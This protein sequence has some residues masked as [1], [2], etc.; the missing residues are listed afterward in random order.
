MTLE[1]I[2]IGFIVDHDPNVSVESHRNLSAITVRVAARCLRL[3]ETV[4][5]CKVA[6]E[7]Q[8]RERW[9][10]ALETQRVRDREDVVRFLVDEDPNVTAEPVV[11][12]SLLSVAVAS[13]AL[14]LSPSAL[15]REVAEAV[16]RKIKEE[17]AEDDDLSDLV[18]SVG[19]VLESYQLN[20][21]ERAAI[22]NVI[23]KW[24][25]TADCFKTVYSKGFGDGVNRALN[26][27][28]SAMEDEE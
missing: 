7:A 17:A 25:E 20:D 14:D 26:R 13:K 15:A 10:S 23:V 27:K 28:L 16:Q 21:A 24:S 8:K 12:A 4:V 11:N 18:D 6:I 3:P 22:K 19:V 1:E 5:A 2:M 9:D